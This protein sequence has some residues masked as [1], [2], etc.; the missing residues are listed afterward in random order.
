MRDRKRILALLLCVGLVTVLAVSSA[1]IVL[2]AGHVCCGRA[3]KTCESVAKTEALL[4]GMACFAFLSLFA[5]VLLPV[6]K[7]FC[8]LKAARQP[9]LDTLVCWKVRLN[10]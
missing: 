10:N 1:F 9:A 7:A 6:L 3:C 8:A 2:E 5:A 4:R